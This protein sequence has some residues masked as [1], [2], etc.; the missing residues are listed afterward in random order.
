MDFK[1]I[2]VADYSNEF[3]KRAIHLYIHRKERDR[4]R[5]QKYYATNEGKAK[6]QLRAKVYYYKVKKNNAYHEKYNP[7][8]IKKTSVL[9]N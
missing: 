4:K 3:I 5:S 9:T 2:K 7:E 8:G 1:N 6:N